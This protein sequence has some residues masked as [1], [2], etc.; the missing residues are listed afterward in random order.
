MKEM[1]RRKSGTIDFVEFP[2]KDVS[3]VASIKQFYSGVFG[4]DFKDWG[5]DYIDTVDSGLPCGFNADPT[6]RPRMPLAVIYT[7]NI[8]SSRD[9]IAKAGGKITRDI[10]CFPGGRRFHFTDPCGNELA[11]WSDI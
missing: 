11:V 7:K 4:W 5:A 10:F 2:A 8:S 6:H 9:Q 1:K 3:A